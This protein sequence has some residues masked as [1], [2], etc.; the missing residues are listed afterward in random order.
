M[1]AFFFFLIDFKHVDGD[2]LQ[3]ELTDVEK[4]KKKKIEPAHTHSIHGW[5]NLTCT[6]TEISV[7]V[8]LLGAKNKAAEERGTSKLVPSSAEDTREGVKA[9]VG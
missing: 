6:R 3:C 9:R 1:Q 7:G 2:V 4:L 5:S 8:E